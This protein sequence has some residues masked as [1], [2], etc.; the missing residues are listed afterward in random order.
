MSLVR[1]IYGSDKLRSVIQMYAHPPTQ[2]ASIAVKLYVSWRLHGR[3]VESA[4]NRNEYLLGKGGRCVVQL[5][6]A[7]RYNSEGRGID[8]RWCHWNFFIDIILPAALW[9]WG[10]LSL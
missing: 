10:R 8:S 5:V 2:Q 7:L 4:S 1:F 3:G 9:P 6:E